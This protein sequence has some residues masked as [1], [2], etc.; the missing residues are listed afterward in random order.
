MP[1]LTEKNYMSDVWKCEDMEQALYSRD[2]A[3]LITG[4][5]LKV[6][7]VLGQITAS[8]KFTILAPGA[9]DGSQVAA[10]VLLVDT[11]ATAADVKTV[12]GARDAVVPDNKLIWPGGISGPQKTT[13][14]GQL[15]SLGILVRTGV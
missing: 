2:N 11:D 15:K 7:T 10:G 9:S 6:G 13:A 12:I 14:I 1:I 8:G 4:Q 5:N 3:I